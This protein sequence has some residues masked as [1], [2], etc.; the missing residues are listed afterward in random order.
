MKDYKNLKYEKPPTNSDIIGALIL[1]I[2]VF[3]GWLIL[4]LI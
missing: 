4:N 1:V 2:V 3:G